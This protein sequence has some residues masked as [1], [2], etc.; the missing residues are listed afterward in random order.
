MGHYR[1]VGRFPNFSFPCNA[2]FYSFATLHTQIWLKDDAGIHPAGGE[3]TLPANS[4]R[5]R[6][7]GSACLLTLCPFPHHVPHPFPL[8]VPSRS[9]EKTTSAIAEVFC[10]TSCVWPSS[11]KVTKGKASHSST[12][13]GAC[14][15][16]PFL[17]HGCRT[18]QVT[19]Y[20]WQSRVTHF[21]LLL[22]LMCLE[23]HAALTR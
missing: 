4:P 13:L 23:E 2:I 6:P 9:Q 10:P 19:Q 22:Q 18:F 17:H 3:S 15:S 14:L 21:S 20:G 11:N 8:L 7:D 16:S 5:R 12:C 1:E